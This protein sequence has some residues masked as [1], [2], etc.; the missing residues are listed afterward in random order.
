MDVLLDGMNPPPG[1]DVIVEATT[2]TFMAEVV[3]ASRER[4]VLVDFWAD[5]CGP[6]KQLTPMLEKI[7]QEQAGRVRLV[8]INVDEN[9]AV[10]QQLRIQ[11]LPTVMAFRNGQ[12]VDAFAGALPESELRK[13]I[14]GLIGDGLAKESPADA[15]AAQGLA[16]L[17]A[18]ET[19][20]AAQIFEHI[21]QAEPDHLEATGGLARALLD[22]G[23]VDEAKKMLAAVPEKHAGDPAIAGARAALEL[24]EQSA[25]AGDVAALEAQLQKAPDDNQARYDLALALQAHGRID[26]AAEELLEIISR[27]REWNGDAARKQLL[28]MFD[29]AGPTSAFTQRARRRLSSLLFS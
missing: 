28:K 25:E 18:G 24:R 7:V 14:G 6:C 3:E 9:Q 22:L 11:S 8:K 13:F 10:A 4:P 17:D 15:L 26:E 16:A 20:K 27:D 2:E 12:P 29:A 19:D 23:R 5:W 21:L 1:G